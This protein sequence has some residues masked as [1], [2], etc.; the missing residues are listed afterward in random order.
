MIEGKR[1]DIRFTEDGDLFFFEGKVE[2][3]NNEENEL[4]LD[5]L[6]RRLQ[7][8]IGDWRSN[9]ALEN[10]INNYRGEVLNETIV[11]LIGEEI[12]RILI[13]EEIVFEENILVKA[14]KADPE[15]VV[16][17]VEIYNKKNRNRDL[18][19]GFVYDQRVN[20]IIPRYI[21]PRGNEL[22]RG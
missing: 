12:R 10:S 7:S 9:K 11:E 16:F 18:Y 19:L 20:Q 4:L 8:Y 15:S 13:E 6:F 1:K 17:G 3:V 14:L 2:S 21:K 5:I 22:W